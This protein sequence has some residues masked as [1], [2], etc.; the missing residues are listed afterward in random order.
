MRGIDVHLYRDVNR[1]AVHSGALHGLARAA[2]GWLVVLVLA[3]CL[4]AAWQLARRRPDAPVAVA[5]ALWALAAA[6][7][8]DAV[9]RAVAAAV[10]RAR[11]YDLVPHAEVLVSRTHLAGFPAAGA[12]AAAAVAGALWRSEAGPA[13]AATVAA[14]CLGFAQVYAGALY[15]GD[16][17]TGYALGVLVAL[18]L[19]PLGLRVLSWLTV[20]VERSPLHLIVA[21]HRV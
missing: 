20:K 3:L 9:A 18:A 5:S 4:L 19:R 8:S 1:L 2:A 13:A 10:G 17:L 11:P 21:A 7:V 16:V 6:L 14:L 15:P 12:A